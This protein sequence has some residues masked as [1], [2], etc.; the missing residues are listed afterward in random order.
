MYQD[1]RTMNIAYGKP[2]FP[3][4]VVQWD[5][6]RSQCKNIKDEYEELV[7]AINKKDQIEVRDAICDILVFTLGAC[8]FLDM[9]IESKVDFNRTRPQAISLT[10]TELLASAALIH[11]DYSLLMLSIAAKDLPAVEENLA[12]IVAGTL[13]IADMLG[14]PVEA[15]MKAVFESNMSKFC[16]DQDEVNRTVSKYQAIGLEVYLDGVFPA[17]CV[18]SFKDQ[19]CWGG[20]SYPADKMLKGINYRKPVFA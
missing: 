5:K 1:V 6:L 4:G 7:V 20:E 19:T 16:A 18:K 11:N 12:D 10:T 3:M 8:H 9:D 17:K 2:K 14:Q 15:D 13:V